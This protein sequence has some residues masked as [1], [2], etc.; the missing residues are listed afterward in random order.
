[1]VVRKQADEV[2]AVADDAQK[3][4]DIASRLQVTPV[5]KQ[6]RSLD[7]S[8]APRQCPP[9]KASWQLSSS[10]L[11]CF[12]CSEVPGFFGQERHSGVELKESLKAFSISPLC[13]NLPARNAHV[14]FAMLLPPLKVETACD[15][16]VQSFVMGLAAVVLGGDRRSSR[17]RSP[18]HW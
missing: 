4:L 17:L 6:C 7:R 11:Y 15:F 10:E 2:K 16:E 13:V 5:Q 12:R 1:M 9:S 14:P 3:D 18:R 8:Q